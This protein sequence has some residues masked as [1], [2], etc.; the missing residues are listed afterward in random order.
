MPRLA[1]H[2]G[3]MTMGFYITLRLLLTLPEIGSGH[4]V[5]AMV[6]A[7][8]AMANLE[9]QS[10]SAPRLEPVSSNQSTTPTDQIDGGRMFAQN[11]SSLSLVAA[12]VLH[13]T[14][15]LTTSS[16]M[17]DLRGAIL[18]SK[19]SGRTRSYSHLQLSPRNFLYGSAALFVGMCLCS[20]CLAVM[21]DTDVEEQ[22]TNVSSTQASTGAGKS[23]DGRGRNS[24]FK[25]WAKSF[26]KWARDDAAHGD[27][28]TPQDRVADTLK[29]SVERNKVKFA[30]PSSI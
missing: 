30:T 2:M 10:G 25:K 22:R 6:D 12:D 5:H 1:F 9:N 16:F 13:S 26:A 4:R 3:S 7:C 11:M 17:E 15:K 18:M 28:D 19:T 20:C 8:G 29:R 24:K 27:K 23:S 14:H 21:V